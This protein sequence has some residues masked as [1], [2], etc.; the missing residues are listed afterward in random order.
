MLS[1]R[2]LIKLIEMWI[3]H[4]PGSFPMDRGKS[5]TWTSI[6]I[7]VSRLVLVPTTGN[8]RPNLRGLLRSVPTHHLIV[9]HITIV[10][11]IQP[12]RH[13]VVLRMVR[14]DTVRIHG[15]LPIEVVPDPRLLPL[16]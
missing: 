14:T 9:V 11:V 16:S 3:I 1:G 10:L 4:V 7:I 13:I 12:R 8:A 2:L 6:M 5:A 15:L